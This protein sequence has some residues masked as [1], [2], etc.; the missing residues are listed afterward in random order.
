MITVT[1]FISTQ[2]NSCNSIL[3][4][5]PNKLLNSTLKCDKL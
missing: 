4:W 5:I 3:M 2:C 1:K